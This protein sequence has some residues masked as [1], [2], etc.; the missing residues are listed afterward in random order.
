MKKWNNGMLG[1]K[2]PLLLT[3]DCQLQTGDCLT[4]H[5]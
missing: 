2:I 3:G 4:P 5:A 1:Y